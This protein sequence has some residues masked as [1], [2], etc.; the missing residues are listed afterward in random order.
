MERTP[1]LVDDGAARPGPRHKTDAIDRLGALASTAC[2]VHCTL[3]ALVPSALAAVGLGALLG[4]GT[5]WV[6][7]LVAVGFAS[8]AL[9]L[10]WR[11]HRSTPAAGALA[12]GIVGLLVARFVEESGAHELGTVIAVLSGVV[13]VVGH[14]LNLRVSRRHAC[15]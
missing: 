3:A 15:A 12:A 13:L 1:E 7:T 4:H 11:K 5:E 6:F 8:V 9:G 2:A 10:G 14:A